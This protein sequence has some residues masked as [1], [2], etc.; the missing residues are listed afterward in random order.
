MAKLIVAF[1]DRQLTRRI[2]HALETEGL[3]VFRACCTGNEVMRAFNICQD[4]ILVCGTHFADRTVDT[5]AW[6]LGKRVL[7]LAV[8]R[9]EQLELCE[10]PAIHRL[11]AP[12]SKRELAA[13]V[14]ALLREHYSRL[15]HRSEQEKTLIEAAKKILMQ[16]FGLTEKQ[17][18][19]S[20]Q[21]ES[22]R[23]GMKMVEGARR[24][25]AEKAGECTA[26]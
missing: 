6:D 11:Q 25:I 5:L 13:C 19:Q 15:P 2:S 26:R 9:A 21:K 22:M 16:E 1:R 8:G 23:H 7:I 14:N 3:E 10:H 24:I 4:G 12:F 20:L 17:A 18:H